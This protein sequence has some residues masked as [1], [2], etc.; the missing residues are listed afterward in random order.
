MN[1]GGLP[2]KGCATLRSHVSTILLRSRYLYT[3]PICGPPLL[4]RFMCVSSLPLFTFSVTFFVLSTSSITDSVPISTSVCRIL[5]P[6]GWEILKWSTPGPRASTKK[7]EKDGWTPV[8]GKRY[9][10]PRAEEEHAQDSHLKQT[11]SP[12]R[13]H[14]ARSLPARLSV[15]PSPAASDAKH[16]EFTVLEEVSSPYEYC[17]R[18]AFPESKTSLRLVISQ[19][20]SSETFTADHPGQ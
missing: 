15:K 20:F 13:S 19:T 12:E 10:S 8:G 6:L 9:R 5:P 1:C 17:L 14:G 7:Q 18:K 11:S 2:T 3:V 4:V 16:P